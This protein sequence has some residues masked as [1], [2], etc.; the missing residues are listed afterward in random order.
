MSATR[1]TWLPLVALALAL[2]LSACA[3]EDDAADDA[4]VE[5]EA[6]DREEMANM[7]GMEM[8]DTTESAVWAH[9]QEADYRANWQL[10]PGTEE[11]YAGTEPHGMLLTTYANSL[12]MEALADGSADD[13]PEGAIIVKENY[14]PDSTF[15]AATVMMKVDGYNPDHANWLFAKYQPDGTVDAF[16]RPAGCQS[17]HQQAEGDS[18][19]YTAVGQ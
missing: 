1:F 3:P 18:Y 15:A 2:P 6:V 8:P 13:L 4:T 9:L 16:G 11:L 17:C 10:W 7:N 14:M 5:G 19:I 12:A